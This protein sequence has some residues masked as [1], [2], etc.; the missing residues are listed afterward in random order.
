MQIIRNIE[1][2][3]FN[4]ARIL[5][6]GTFDGVHLGHQQIFNLMKERAEK[7][8]LQSTVVSFD[9]HPRVFLKPDSGIK[10]LT[11]IDQKSEILEKLGVD[12][13][14]VLPF[15]TELSQ[16][17]SSEFLKE[18]LLEKIGLSE[19][20]V[21]YDHRFG[22]GRDGDEVTIRKF[23]AENN[24]LVHKIEAVVSND[25]K[26][27]SSR[28]REMLETGRVDIAA[29]LLGRYYCFDGTVV[30]G[31]QRGRK[32]GYPT[33]N[34]GETD[35]L[36]QMP[37]NGVYA[38]AV[39][40]DDRLVFGVMNSG[41]RPTFDKGDE[42]FREIHLFQFNEDIYGR[43]LRVYL[44]EKIRDEMKFSSVDAL[45]AQIRADAE[46]AQSI[47]GKIEKPFVYF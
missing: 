9:P 20:A 8:N 38:V 45:V 43:R 27:S 22:K 47:I 26:V 5:T 35:P 21:G 33:A 10:I 1:S 19:I 14:I 37:Q 40:I 29:H 4:P 42:I 11:S 16:K 24:I 2:V 17:S 41:I 18:Y 15:N 28:V 30:S 12:L 39:S 34:I 31:L 25:G 3:L 7:A 6:V 32:L 23:A 46:A 36:K 44:I 13:F